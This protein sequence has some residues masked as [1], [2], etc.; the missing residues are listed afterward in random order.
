MWTVAFK[1]NSTSE[2]GSGYY[3]PEIGSF[4]YGTPMDIPP[5]FSKKSLAKQWAERQKKSKGYVL[6]YMQM[7]TPV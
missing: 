2:Q 3:E 4:V 5:L 6:V 1:T 7:G